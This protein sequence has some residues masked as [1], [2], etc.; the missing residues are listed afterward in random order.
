[1][2]LLARRAADALQPLQARLALR[3]MIYQLINVTSPPLQ[4][5]K[6]ADEGRARPPAADHPF[7]DVNEF[8]L[9]F[10]T[11]P[12]INQFLHRLLILELILFPL[13]EAAQMLHSE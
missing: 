10:K 7:V 2:I 9:T 13:L 4:L 6:A 1:M 5:I 11:K 3:L 8:F 12:W